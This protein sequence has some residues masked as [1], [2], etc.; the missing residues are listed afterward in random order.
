MRA[1][2]SR[3]R[4]LVG[5]SKGLIG[6]VALA[7]AACA[8][9]GEPCS[10]TP[11]S[12]GSKTSHLICADKKYVLAPCKGQNGCNDDGKSLVCDNTKADLGDGCSPE[13]AR[14]CS[15]DGSKELRCRGAHFAVEWSCRGGCKLDESSNP[16]C[17][18]TG[19]AGDACRP[20]S[21][22]CD[23]SQTTELVCTDG[24]LAKRRTCHGALGCQT[25][26]GGGVR[27]DRTIALEGEECVDEGTGACDVSRKNVLVCSGGHYRT[28]LHCLGALGCELPGNYSVRCDKSLVEE[29]EA[30]TEESSVS[31]STEGKQV[32][33]TEGKFAR[34]KKWKP[35]KGETCA[36][37]Y[38]V[39]FETA[40]FE[41]R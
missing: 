5:R 21:I 39:S 10:D 4:R 27:C 38:R 20:D 22:V 19:E 14:A 41:A 29:G 12:C 6:L 3:F 28:Q 25:E 13:G 40:K 36:N 9:P 8:K 37:R 23:G 11:G 26:P 2:L 33:C 7:V 24:K 1:V 15:T 16:K 34:D 17:T 30:C 18:P 32:K 31:C 35:K